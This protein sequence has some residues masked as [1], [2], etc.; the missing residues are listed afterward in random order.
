M[1]ARSVLTGGRRSCPCRARGSRRSSPLRS[2]TAWARLGK[3]RKLSSLSVSWWVRVCHVRVLPVFATGVGK[4]ARRIH[5]LR[6]DSADLHIE[7]RNR[8]RITWTLRSE[9]SSNPTSHIR[10]ASCTLSRGPAQPGIMSTDAESTGV[11]A[12]GWSRVRARF[13]AYST[14]A[15]GLP[16]H[17]AA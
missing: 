6:F 14:F 8:R 7:S 3:G 4:R 2:E 13:V 12:S 11:V 16:P 9:N 17:A 5:R 15:P 10:G 1:P